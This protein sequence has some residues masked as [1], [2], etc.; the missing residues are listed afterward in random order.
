MTPRGE[1]L[2][3]CWELVSQGGRCRDVI[4][5][6][7]AQNERLH[8]RVTAIVRANKSTWIMDWGDEGVRISHFRLYPPRDVGLPEAMRKSWAKRREKAKKDAE[9]D[10][11]LSHY[12]PSLDAN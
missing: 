4:S 2:R 7:T 6:L 10:K 9:W 1:G 8:E 11:S 5:F 3:C 12:N